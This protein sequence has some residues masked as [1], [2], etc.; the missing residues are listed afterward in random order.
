MCSLLVLAMSTDLYRHTMNTLKT[1][2]AV[3]NIVRTY[4]R[5]QFI[6]AKSNSVYF[7]HFFA[8][9]IYPARF[10]ITFVYDAGFRGVQNRN[11]FN[12]NYCVS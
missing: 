4:L 12:F 9:N 3:Y 7:E 2:P 8:D 11:P 5:H 6:P 10:A 1:K